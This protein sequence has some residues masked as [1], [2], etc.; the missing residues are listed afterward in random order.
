MMNWADYFIYNDEF[1]QQYLTSVGFVHRDIHRHNIIIH[2][3]QPYLIDF[4][5]SGV[6]CRLIEITRP[7]NVYV[8]VDEFL[9]MYT[10]AKR[11]NDPYFSDLER[12]I[13]DRVLVLDIMANL[14]W[15]AR[16]I[17]NAE[18]GEY[19]NELLSFLQNRVAYLHLLMTHRHEFNLDFVS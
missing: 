4:D 9:P 5:F 18:E 15:E 14:G 19:R 7:T 6:D 16:E 3:G 17:Y 11:V 10:Q 12:E 1:K 2:H 13:I 8:E